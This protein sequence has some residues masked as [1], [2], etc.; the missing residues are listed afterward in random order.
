MTRCS[1]SGGHALNHDADQFGAGAEVEPDVAGAGRGRSRSAGA[2]ATRPRSRKAAAG[3]VA[4]VERPAVEPR[5]VARP[6]GGVHRTSGRSRASSLP[7]SVRFSSS[8]TST[9]SSQSSAS[10]KATS[11]ARTPSRPACSARRRQPVRCR[12]RA[13]RSGDQQ[14]RLQPRQVE[15]LRRRGQGEPA[16]PRRVGDLEPR[17][18]RRRRPAPGARGSRRRPP[19]RRVDAQVGQRSS[20]ARGTT[21]PVGLCG[22]ASTRTRVPPSNAASQPRRDRSRR[23]RQGC[24]TARRRQVVKNGRYAGVANATAG[25]PRRAA[26]SSSTPAMTS[27]TSLTCSGSTVHPSRRAANP[28]NASE[29]RG[30]RA[31]RSRG[32][33]G[34]SRHGGPR[35]PAP[36]PGSPSPRRGGSTPAP[37]RPLMP[38]RVCRV[39]SGGTCRSVGP[40]TCGMVSRQFGPTLVEQEWAG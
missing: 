19:S 32:R 8:R 1:G 26:A 13:V 5:E 37:W 14:R 2:R 29:R 15:R 10:E 21:R 6:R 36:R 31:A 3:I 20:S 11:E 12:A 22:L 30:S 33:A 17:H 35:R 7:S 16:P 39:A 27:G 23:C 25:S 9:A 38:R 28:A 18:V 24:T 4:E 34:R 40:I